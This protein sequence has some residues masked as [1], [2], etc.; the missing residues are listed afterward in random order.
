M[1][2]SLFIS[3]I[4]L[5]FLNIASAADTSFIFMGGGGEPE[6]ATTIFDES[7][8]KMKPYFS[9]R[10]FKEGS[11]SFNG[12]HANTER[13]LS[14]AFPQHPNS[15]FTNESYESLIKKYIDDIKNGKYKSGDQILVYIDTHGAMKGKIKG[16]DEISHSIATTGSAI[17]NYNH[18]SG[19]SVVTMDLLKDL[20][21]AAKDAKINLGII[22]QSCH[23]G[24][25]IDLSNE[26][27]CVIS[28][29]GP[30]NYGYA[31][32]GT[33]SDNFVK[34]MKTGRSLEDV[35]LEARADASDAGY[36]MISSQESQSIYK[37]AY[38]LISPYLN[39]YYDTNAD[40]LTN[41][42]KENI[43]DMAYCKREQQFKDLFKMLENVESVFSVQKK[44]FFM[45]W[46]EKTIDL[47]NLKDA[48]K[49]YKESQ[50]QMILINRKLSH[51]KF[52]QELEVE[53]DHI[54]L[55]DLLSTNY[56]GQ[57]ED[58]N[59]LI[60]RSNTS[61][62]RKTFLRNENARLERARNLKFQKANEYPELKNLIDTEDEFRSQSYSNA[63]AVADAEKHFYN[64][65]YKELKKKNSEQANPCRNFKL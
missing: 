49:K 1:K 19:S 65:Y 38:S 12:G 11:V 35:F 50:D 9:S 48:L 10:T 41:Y 7:L 14:E 64:S 36:P 62:A 52:D 5:S 24:N 46:T 47:T 33:F 4:L 43:S 45:K 26:Y 25:S 42:F 60:E 17:R 29:T 13:L 58:N 51:P 40:K 15:S 55:R 6:G 27:T 23:S 2:N 53:G 56:K 32:P 8:G 34:N 37:D 28:S 59:K 39:F 20:A 30:M 63:R 18:L 3:T 57:I 54:T 22:D 31:G 61:E 44:L 21:T 16:K